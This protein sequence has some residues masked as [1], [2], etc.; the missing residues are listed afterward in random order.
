MTLFDYRIIR[1]IGLNTYEVE[2]RSGDHFAMKIL[3][4]PETYLVPE[5]EIRR[6]LNHPGCLPIK[7]AWVARKLGWELDN[8][9]AVYIVS[10]LF[11]K[12]LF[13][14]LQENGGEMDIFRI[15]ELA[16]QLFKTLA[17]IHSQKV[18]HGQVDSQNCLLN[19]DNSELKL[20]SYQFA[21]V[22]DGPV[23]L[24]DQ[25][26]GYS[27]R[28]PEWVWGSSH[29]GFPTDV[30]GAGIV[31]AEMWNGKR[32]MDVK[33][34]EEDV[35]SAIREIL[36]HP[37]SED[38]EEF[39]TGKRPQSREE[40]PPPELKFPPGVASRLGRLDISVKCRDLLSKILVYSPSRRLTAEECLAH[41]YCDPDRWFMLDRDSHWWTPSDAIRP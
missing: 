33:E 6:K 18:L 1:S 29:V 3:F 11:P 4:F 16:V 5:L 10:E 34:S 8:M 21:R 20:C 17:Y 39:R 15:Q 19:E 2:D 14:H 7:V 35:R 30:W 32:L 22:V 31:L 12:T 13:T 25:R 38:L 36:G 41:P 26:T 40:K 9:K 27:H 23:N 28:S 24:K 37:S